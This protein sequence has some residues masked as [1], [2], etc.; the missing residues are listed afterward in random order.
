MNIAKF[1]RTAFFVEHLCWLLL[2]LILLYIFKLQTQDVQ[3]EGVNCRLIEK[4]F[5]VHSVA[6]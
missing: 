2:H 4:I 5:H 1:L 6:A 3:F